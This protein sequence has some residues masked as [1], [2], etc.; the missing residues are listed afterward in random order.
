MGALLDIIQA[1]TIAG[2]N[3]NTGD[4]TVNT[5]NSP[6]GETNQKGVAT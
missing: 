1:K 6:R 5:D 4:S 3:K 2:Y